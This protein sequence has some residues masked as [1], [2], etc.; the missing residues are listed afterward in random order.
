MLT[1]DQIQEL[2]NRLNDGVSKSQVLKEIV[3]QRGY[4]DGVY[5]EVKLEL[6]A[7]GV[8]KIDTRFVQCSDKQY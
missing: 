6:N 5:S 7:M 1:Q 8:T 3:G 2:R 4:F